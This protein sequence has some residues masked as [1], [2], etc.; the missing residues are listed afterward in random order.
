MKKR[1]TMQRIRWSGVG[2]REPHQLSCLV[3]RVQLNTCDSS[4][5]GGCNEEG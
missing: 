4:Y 3:W 5:Y 2:E 1:S